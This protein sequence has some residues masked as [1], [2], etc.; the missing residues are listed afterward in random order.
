[1]V[2]EKEN[3]LSPRLRRFMKPQGFDKRMSLQRQAPTAAAPTEPRS[4]GAARARAAQQNVSLDQLV[5]AERS[6]LRT[7][8]YPGPDCFEPYEIEDHVARR[9]TTERA[10]HA[11]RCEGCRVLLS[12]ASG[13]QEHMA[14][15]L[16]AM[17]AVEIESDAEPAREFTLELVGA[18]AAF[19]AVAGL[20]YLVFRFSPAAADP[21]T[22]AALSTQL[23]QIAPAG[24]MTAG[25]AISLAI[26]LVL[27]IQYTPD[28]LARARGA[29][30][31][32]VVVGVVV[33]LAGWR[34]ATNFAGTMQTGLAYA[35]EQLTNAM[36]A[37]GGPSGVTTG[38]ATPSHLTTTSPLSTVTARTSDNGQSL[39]YSNVKGL[40]GSVVAEIQP[41]GG[42]VYWE[43]ANQKEPLGYI[44]YGKIESSQAADFVLI[45]PT[46][47]EH[48]IKKPAG[49]PEIVK[50]AEVI[51][52]MT[53]A[54]EPVS[55]HPLART[56]PPQ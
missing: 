49:A 43:V 46:Q 30:V 12:G 14:E 25:W 29:I 11:D 33:A 13:P 39:V 52:L 4:F 40:P 36:A 38:T 53:P 3:D 27:R 18:A 48:I 20:G 44:L 35:Q 10:E 24:L 22:Q 15:F 34:N 47:R 54:N 17:E 7:S 5:A 41:S 8:N 45:D 51:V 23:T 2:L 42:N 26:L 19:V 16:A 32:G 50:G 1:L 21:S 9:L 6:R 56:P 31:A 37:A 28:L 55:V